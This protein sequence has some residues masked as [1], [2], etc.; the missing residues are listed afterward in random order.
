MVAGLG[1]G[2]C[3]RLLASGNAIDEC[4]P[5]AEVL[6][7]QIGLGKFVQGEMAIVGMPFYDAA[8]ALDFDVGGDR[9]SALIRCAPRSPD[10]GR[11]VLEGLGKITLAAFDKTGTLAQRPPTLTDVVGFGRSERDVLALAAGLETG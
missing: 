6:L 2:L 5:S 1:F 9:R 7:W 4:V 11:R 10:E 8:F 3:V